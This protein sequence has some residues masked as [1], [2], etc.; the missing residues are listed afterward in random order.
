MDLVFVFLSVVNLLAIGAACSCLLIPEKGNFLRMTL[1]SPILGLL[2]TSLLY[3]FWI[4]FLG[5]ERSAY[6]FFEISTIVIL[7]IA[8]RTLGKQTKE[9]DF[10]PDAASKRFEPHSLVVFAALIVILSLYATNAASLI[11]RADLGGWDAWSRINVK[12]AFLSNVVTAPEAFGEFVH[13]PD[14]PLLLPSSVARFWF[15]GNDTNLL[16]PQFLSV[17]ISLS[18]L[19]VVFDALFSWHSSAIGLVGTVT[20][21]SAVTIWYW[22]GMQYSDLLLSVFICLAVVSL[23][24]LAEAKNEYLGLYALSLGACMWCK[25]EGIAFA[26]ISGLLSLVF[27]VARNEKLR[28]DISVRGFV[29]GLTMVGCLAATLAVKFAA[30]GATD[31]FREQSSFSEKIFN[32]E[33][34][35]KIFVAVLNESQNFDWIV[36]LACIITLV[37]L[38]TTGRQRLRFCRGSW[39]NIA[40]LGLLAGAFFGIYLI[41]PH[42]LEF[43][44]SSSLDRLVMLLWPPIVLTVL[45]SWKPGNNQSANP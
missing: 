5:L 26:S 2:I 24:N 12:A 44:L 18:L 45:L 23:S 3:F 38:L 8:A 41:T 15:L 13:H 40:S 34:I 37:F 1:L 7:S 25:N 39:I 36:L 43:H 33:R 14:Y 4:N 32:L 20:C 11:A 16:V 28:S 42:D 10:E 9:N 29:G 35:Q 27:V 6:V 19:L 22:A 31:L 30:P 17:V 21:F